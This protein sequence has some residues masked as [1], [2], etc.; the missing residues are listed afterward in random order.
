VLLFQVNDIIMVFSSALIVLGI[1]AM[2]FHRV[3]QSKNSLNNHAS[4]QQGAAD[5]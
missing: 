4:N 2:I 1:T 5:E 3:S